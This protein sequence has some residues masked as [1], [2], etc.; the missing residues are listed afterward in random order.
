MR[1]LLYAAAVSML[2]TGPAVGQ[3]ELYKWV[4]DEGNVTYQD[5]P[6]PDNSGQV[7]TIGETAE[8][9]AA[10]ELPDVDVVLYAIEVCES[11]DLVRNLLTER[12]VPFSERDAEADAEIQEELKEIAGVLSVPVLVIG[13]DEVLTGY[14]RDLIEN[15]LEEAGFVRG[16]AAE[17]ESTPEMTPGELEQAARDAASDLEGGAANEQ[18]AVPGDEDDF[19]AFDEELP[20]EDPGDDVTQWEEIPEDERISVGE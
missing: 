10:A 16:A 15:E 11:C 3:D 12:G 18:G 2:A 17:P 7:Q 19:A 1:M 14:N 6:P 8:E 4:D 5:R 20:F 13:G 9:T